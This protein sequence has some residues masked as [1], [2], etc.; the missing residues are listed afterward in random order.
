MQSSGRRLRRFCISLDRDV[1]KKLSSR[2][3]RRRCYALRDEMKNR[4]SSI[5]VVI[6]CA[7][8]ART[9]FANLTRRGT[10]LDEKWSLL[11]PPCF[12]AVSIGQRAV[13]L[14]LD[15]EG[16]F[17]EV[18]SVASGRAFLRSGSR[19]PAPHLRALA[20]AVMHSGRHASMRPV[21]QRAKRRRQAKL[22]QTRRPRSTIPK[23]RRS[24]R[25][26]APRRRDGKTIKPPRPRD[27]NASNMTAQS[28]SNSIINTNSNTN[29]IRQLG[30][31]SQ[32]ARGP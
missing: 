7:F 18:G 12:E 3:A 30:L 9:T 14:H 2:R 31:E 11:A 8:K 28:N 25:G 27:A 21:A 15:R 1:E 32:P 4:C 10:S 16:Y 26:K 5:S 17:S 29:R 24:R 20:Y 23:S 22:K 6:Q 13:G 19:A